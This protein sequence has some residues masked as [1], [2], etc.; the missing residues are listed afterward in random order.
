VEIVVCEVGLGGRLDATNVL[1]PLVAAITS[2][3]MDHQRYLGHTVREIALE[4][5]GVIKAGTPVVVGPID[6]EPLAEIERVAGARGAP[7]IRAVATADAGPTFGS[8]IHLR[9]PVHDYGEVTL[10][11]AGDH[12]IANALVAVRVLEELNALGLTV[13]PSAVVA[14][15]SRVAWPGR[16]DL[17]TLPDGRQILMDAAHNPDGA[18]ALAA[19]L[20]QQ[21][22]ERPP[23]VFA[24]M[25]DKDAPAMLEALVSAIGALILTC[26]SNSRAAD[27]DELAAHA[28][29][30]APALPM[31]IERRVSDALNAAWDISPRI[32][33]AGSIF[34]LGDVIVEITRRGSLL[35][36]P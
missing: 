6:F 36:N 4:K 28:R 22:R 9:T 21:Q 23:L 12:Q 5:A 31:R 35:K 24:V 8:A 34:L 3:G 15:V 1:K 26:V 13:P 11:L 17:R 16:L 33:A 30:I 32:V 25:S 2:I 29:R 10:G 7:L 20:R 18:R 14:G 27:P 19:F